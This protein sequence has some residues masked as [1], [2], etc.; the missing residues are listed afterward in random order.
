MLRSLPLAAGYA[1]IL[2]LYSEG[3]DSL[4]MDSVA[5]EAATPATGERPAWSVR[6]ADPAIVETYVIDAASRRITK[7]DIVSRRSGRR[8]HVLGADGA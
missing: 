4:E 6:F 5:G 3:S 7:H 1:A 2:P 8:V